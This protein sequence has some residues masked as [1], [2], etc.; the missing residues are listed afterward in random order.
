MG[1]K[2]G[3][4]AWGSQ[5]WD[6][7]TYSAY[8]EATWNFWPGAWSPPTAKGRDKYPTYMLPQF[9]SYDDQA[10][11]QALT[12]ATA[13]QTA[14]SKGRGKTVEDADMTDP[15][16]T[17]TQFLQEA[18][19]TTRKSEQKMRSLTAT[20]A[21]KEA[22]WVK[23]VEDMKRTLQ[24]EHQRHQK[25]ME[26]LNADIHMA[27]Q[28]QEQA[29]GHLRHSWEAIAAY[30]QPPPTTESA[31]DT[32][33]DNMLEAW[34]AEQQDSTAPQAVLRRALQGALPTAVPARSIGAQDELLHTPPRKP[35]PMPSFT[36][37]ATTPPGLSRTTDPYMTSPGQPEMPM[38]DASATGQVEGDHGQDAPAPRSR[39]KSTDPRAPV[40]KLP[41]GVTHTATHPHSDIADK[42]NQK[43]AQI[44]EGGAMNP[45]RIASAGPTALPGQEEPP[46]ERNLL[47]GCEIVDTD[48]ED[49]LQPLPR[50]PQEKME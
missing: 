16:D 22:L 6:Y 8:P 25:E 24:K 35:T 21:K 33:W 9:P 28:A 48:D 38:V 4:G 29:R 27:A 49:L 45:F 5:S 15:A 36:P 23:Y 50:K 31:Q 19:N 47:D 1:K 44:L 37:T 32:S 30:G 34:Q 26:R 17:V 13:A 3:K 39:P 10:R 18:I 41:A 46:P 43:R 14:K 11:V 20:K 2:A 42:L 40:K 12:K 7:A